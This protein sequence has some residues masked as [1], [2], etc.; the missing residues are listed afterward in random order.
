MNRVPVLD[1]MD[2]AEDLLLAEHMIDRMQDLRPGTERIVEGYR[3]EFQAGIL[4]FLLQRPPA[5]I[6]FAR[7][8]A[9]KREDRLLLITN[10]ENGAGHAIAGAGA[11]REFGN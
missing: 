6:E 2:A 11:R 10:S 8:C 9:L 5:Q 3:I 1:R 4:E 7:G